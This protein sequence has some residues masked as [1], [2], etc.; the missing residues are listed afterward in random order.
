MSERI[1][2]PQMDTS[3]TIISGRPGIALSATVSARPVSPLAVAAFIESTS[4]QEALA[5]V[6]QPAFK[7]VCFNGGGAG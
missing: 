6:S 4:E 7:D 3:V 1:D 5:G 2:E